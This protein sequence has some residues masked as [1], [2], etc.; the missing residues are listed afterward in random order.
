MSG[1]ADM[2]QRDNAKIFNNPDEFAEK[3]IVVYDGATYAGAD[4]GGI[5]V[6]LQKITQKNRDQPSV[7]HAQGIY[8]VDAQLF[9]NVRDLDGVIPEKGSRIRVGDG[10]FFREFT[11]AT[12]R[13]EMG[14]VTLELEAFDE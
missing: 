5:P 6:T 1:F 11:V 2:V 13:C 8:R 4:G 3:R 7:D 14:E 9:A 12:S 10:G